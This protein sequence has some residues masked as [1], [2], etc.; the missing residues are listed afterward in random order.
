VANGKSCEEEKMDEKKIEKRNA[1]LRSQHLRKK[2]NI[3]TL[4]QNGRG[5]GRKLN[6]SWRKKRQRL[7]ENNVNNGMVVAARMGAAKKEMSGN[8][9][10]AIFLRTALCA[11][12]RTLQ[13]RQRTLADMAA[14]RQSAHANIAWE[15]LMARVH[16]KRIARFVFVTWRR[17]LAGDNKRHYLA[18]VGTVSAGS[19]A[20]ERVARR[21]GYSTV[22]TLRVGAFFFS[23][24]AACAHCCMPL[25]HLVYIAGASGAGFCRVTVRELSSSGTAPH[26]R[27]SHTSSLSTTAH[28]QQR[29]A[30]RG[31][32][33][34]R[35]PAPAGEPSYAPVAVFIT[36]QHLL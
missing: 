14:L 12:P 3:S 7:A 2:M 20:Y 21:R 31:G 5:T 13:V 17:A 1:A 16:R 8:A 27:T 9:H 11:S 36:K 26:R 10:R 33:E 25:L 6:Q 15:L 29:Q 18:C 4:W 32:A 34:W 23:R 35:Q 19:S 22:F 30:V 28:L 24:R